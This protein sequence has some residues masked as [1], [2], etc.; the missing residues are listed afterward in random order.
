MQL[1]TK[2]AFTRA[3]SRG[4]FHQ[5]A[6]VQGAAEISEL[7]ETFNNM[8]DDIENF[9]AQLKQAAEELKLKESTVRRML[10]PS[11]VT[12]RRS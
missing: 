2:R 6:P 11:V 12:L 9:I 7:A 4:E 8:A 1:L 3:I 10:D 5:R